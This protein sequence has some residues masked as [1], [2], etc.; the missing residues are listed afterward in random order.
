MIF[1]DLDKDLLFGNQENI[2]PE[3]RR[4][5]TSK[6]PKQTRKYKQTLD[7]LFHFRGVWPRLQQLDN[8]P[9]DSDEAREFINSLDIEITNCMLAAVK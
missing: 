1:I 6:H 7:S 4:E 3:P 2:P 9:Q 8:L 5:F